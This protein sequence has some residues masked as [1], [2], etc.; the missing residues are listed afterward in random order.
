MSDSSCIHGEEDWYCTSCHDAFVVALNQRAL[1]AEAALAEA[2]EER[3]AY[4]RERKTCVDCVRDLEDQ[5]AKRIKS[6]GELQQ[7]VTQQAATIS[8]L[9]GYVKLY[10]EHRVTCTY[11]YGKCDC[12][13][14][15]AL[16]T[17]SEPPHANDDEVY[18]QESR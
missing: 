17:L 14:D 3:D 12:G 1:A 13:L 5:V 16:A 18:Y 11:E 6:V 7:Q 2:R 15:A 10:S 9:G 4:K 8:Q